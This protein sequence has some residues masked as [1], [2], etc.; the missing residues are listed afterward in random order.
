MKKTVLES[1]RFPVNADNLHIVSEQIRS[2][3]KNYLSMISSQLALL[4]IFNWL[5]WS[6]LSHAALFWYDV[7]GG[8][9]WSVEL[10][11]WW[12]MRH[13]TESLED[14][15]RWHFAFIS[16]TGFLALFWGSSALWL[17]PPDLIYQSVLLM[18]LM[19]LAAASVSTN[20]VYPASFYVW[21]TGVLVPPIAR[22]ISMDGEVYQATA[23]FIA[24]YYAVLLKSGSEVAGAFRDALVQRM[25]K[26]RVIQQLVA[27]QA[28]VNQ[29][30]ADAE[31]A[32]LEKSRFFA[33]AS[34]DLRQPMQAL[35]LFSDAL[36]DAGA[37]EVPRLAGQIGK[38]VNAL[39]GMFDELLDVSR[40]DAGVVE[41][42]WK[43][44]RLQPLLDD[45]AGDMTQLA[46]NKG[47]ALVIGRGDWVLYS[48]PLLLQRVLNNLVSNAIRYTDQGFVRVSCQ[49]AEQ[50]WRI[51][52]EDSGI[53]M[54]PEAQAHIFEEYY[55]VHN[56]QRD[57][58]KGLGLGL[59]IVRRIESLL[60]LKI[61]VS[62]VPGTGS[63]FSFVVADGN[64]EQVAQ[65]TS[66]A[67]SRYNIAGKAVA[68]VED[69]PEIRGMLVNL[70]RGWGCTVC[71]GESAT[72]VLLQFM[73]QHSQPDL[74]VCDYRLL[75]NETAIHVIRQMRKQWGEDLPAIVL[76]GDTAAATVQEINASGG[77]MLHKPV[78]PERL[79][80]A[81]FF[82]VARVIREPSQHIA[83]GHEHDT[84]A[85]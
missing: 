21:I 11:W 82:A 62:S 26:E 77:I 80:A 40:L 33:A 10:L 8:L 7:L 84:A 57:R 2:R 28:V 30:R 9:A 72:E 35:M 6:V 41:P 71:A 4:A 61:D 37:Q 67:F 15:T 49:R 1:L 44:F 20:T 63:T 32:S 25:G 78:A 75:N 31:S 42:H 79:R 55:Q 29:A 70:M 19:G 53:G 76:T 69:E 45:I 51:Q 58:R 50:G 59:A 65:P 34:H 74:L 73:Q 13:R 43:S 16:F 17:F 64:A 3:L 27:Q 54:T 56:P 85:G 48:D 68:L 24:L 5:M 12:R 36:T 83:L 60:G 81:M 66:S 47:V 22:C 18:L 39:A 14:C 23:V 52:V 38:S 46:R